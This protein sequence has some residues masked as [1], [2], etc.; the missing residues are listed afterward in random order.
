MLNTRGLLLFSFTL[1]TASQAFAL[2]QN[3]PPLPSRLRQTPT[4]LDGRVFFSATERRTLETKPAPPAIPTPIPVTPSPPKRRFDGILWRGG[5][6]VALWFDGEPVDPATEP[7]IRI[8]NGVP[9]TE[10]SG[11]RR[12]LSPGQNWP[13]QD[14]KSEP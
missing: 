7:A 12:T 6:I 8:G 13:L 3:A 5:R 9:G 2:E 1:S 10:I 4:T 11:R 14:R